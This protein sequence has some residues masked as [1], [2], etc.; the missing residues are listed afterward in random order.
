MMDEELCTVWSKDECQMLQV[1]NKDATHKASIAVSVAQVQTW[2]H[3]GDSVG[4]YDTSSFLAKESLDKC[5][6]HLQS[7]QLIDREWLLEMLRTSWDRMQLASVSN[8]L[9]EMAGWIWKGGCGHQN[10]S[11]RDLEPG[12][13]MACQCLARLR[14]VN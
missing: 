14:S 9:T 1:V 6:H 5:I 11:F 7:D 2:H 12:L 13:L 3:G 8:A 10:R 4:C